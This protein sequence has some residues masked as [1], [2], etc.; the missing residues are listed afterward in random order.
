MKLPSLRL[1]VKDARQTLFRF[2]LVIAD[3]AI[4]T[5]AAIIL[6]DYEGPPQPSILFKV[7]FATLLGIPFLAGI[8]ITAER[9]LW[10][11]GL[12]LAL[13]GVGVLLLIGYASTVPTDLAF[14]PGIEIIRLLLLL[15][16]LFLFL[17]VV[18]WL[19]SPGSNGF[20]Q[21]CKTLAFRF[22]ATVLYGFIL[23]AGLALALAALDNLFGIQIDGKRYWELWILLA[24][25]FGTWFFL[26]GIPDQIAR[27]E[28]GNRISQ[29]AEGFDEFCAPPTG[30]DLPCDSV[31]VP[32]EDSY[33]L[34][35]AA[36][37]GEHAH[38]RF[39]GHR[40][41]HVPLVVSGS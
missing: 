33:C 25:L 30:P 41:A 28:R 27:L 24:G 17:T 39:L 35:L 9:R 13:Q 40:I 36:G 34:G 3:A 6:A 31:R 26:A 29:R 14:G 32:R 10:G 2:P 23:F 37:M 8:A 19:G 22:L 12:S 18:P 21:F 16:A 11:K 1:A 38:P 15:V 20:W 7:L 5:A 4:G